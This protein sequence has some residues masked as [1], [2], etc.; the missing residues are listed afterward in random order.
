MIVG[1]NMRKLINTINITIF[2]LTYKFFHKCSSGMYINTSVCFKTYLICLQQEGVYNL[3]GFYGAYEYR[4]LGFY[5]LL[6]T[7][8]T[9]TYQ[10]IQQTGDIIQFNLEA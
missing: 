9:I 8:R 3:C 6:F 2:V 5:F 10:Q 1:S 4:C 7:N